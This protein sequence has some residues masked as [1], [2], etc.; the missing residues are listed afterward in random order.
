MMAPVRIFVACV[1]LLVACGGAQVDRGKRPTVVLGL[2]R[3]SHTGEPVALATIELRGPIMRSTATS[4]SGT[5]TFD[6][7]IPGTYSLKGM[8]AGQ[9]IDITKILVREGESTY[10][11][12]TFTLGDPDPH[13]IVY[14][15]HASDITRY[16]PQ[17]IAPSAST[18]EGTISDIQTR[19]RIA[20]AV[21]T[22]TLDNPEPHT[23]QT[24]SDDHGRYRFENLTPGSYTVSAY[25]SIG[26]HGQVEFQRSKIAVSPAEAVNVPLLIELAK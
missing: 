12:L 11:D 7:L 10:V 6:N 8:Y 18:I 25:Y 15:D 20:G 26:H 16:R 24:V 4:N 22:A 19:E 17:D 5:Y 9:S 13:P 23:E 2:A 14:G 3:D 1:A 21:V